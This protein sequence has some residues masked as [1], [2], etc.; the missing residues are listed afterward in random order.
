MCKFTEIEDC[1]CKDVRKTVHYSIGHC[2]EDGDHSLCEPCECDCHI[3][4]PKGCK[5]TE[6]LIA[7]RNAV[8]MVRAGL[9]DIGIVLMPMSRENNEIS[10]HENAYDSLLTDIEE[11]GCNSCVYD[12][13]EPNRKSNFV[14]FVAEFVK[15]YGIEGLAKEQRDIFL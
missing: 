14:Q 8:V 3:E 4:E 1:G 11:E 13:L 6:I 10:R 7:S 12:A 9:R 15:N 2:F 5:H